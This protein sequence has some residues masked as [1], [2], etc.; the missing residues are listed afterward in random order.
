MTTFFRN[1]IVTNSQASG[2][3]KAY[4][5]SLVVGII[6]L[7]SL[8][9]GVFYLI[10]NFNLSGRVRWQYLVIIIIA[11]VCIVL[12]RQGKSTLAMSL[13][14]IVGNV[15]IFY[16]AT[17]IS[18][19]M[20]T[21]LFFISCSLSALAYFGY[22]QRVLAYL[23]LILSLS[24]FLFAYFGFSNATEKSTNIYYVF[25]FFTTMLVS[26]LVVYFIFNLNHHAE[27]QL[28]EKNDMLTKA[29]H[30]L[31][32]FVYS[33]SHDLQAPLSSL[34]GLIEITQQA[35][36]SQEANRCLDMMKVRINDLDQFI[37]EV[38]DYSRNSRQTI[39]IE[40]F[41][42]TE[43]AREVVAAL[44]F[45]QGFSDILVDYEIATSQQMWTDRARLKIILSNLIG[46][47]MKYHDPDKA[48][49]RISISFKAQ[50]NAWHLMVEDNGIGIAPE[51]KDKVFN[52]FFRAS[53]K[54]S[55]SGLGLYIVQ[56]TL[57]KLGALVSVE[58]T[59]GRG[60][61]FTVIFPAREITA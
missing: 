29:N 61:V 18:N 55:G 43:L 12:N 52:M 54:S 2:D 4:R 37:K 44:Q 15:A 28:R 21:H 60:S 56:E 23:F 39:S 51:Y 32:K 5:R 8:T 41:D 53:E 16:F 35:K 14:L 59:L 47:A 27:A 1:L 25:N 57:L 13:Q 30:E 46:N 50:E 36:D 34:L 42:V 58:S 49:K 26:A 38:I 11:L 40:K 17:F 45:T 20:G 7:V 10:V 3:Y 22:Q 31:D 9:I 6:C 19:R 48:E 33:A 24:L